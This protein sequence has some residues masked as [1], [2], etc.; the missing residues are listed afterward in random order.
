MQA[1]TS[2]ARREART[3]PRTP[4]PPQAPK[5]GARQSRGAVRSSRSLMRP[6]RRSSSHAPRHHTPPPLHARHPLRPQ[7]RPQPRANRRR[8]RAR[9]GPDLKLSHPCLRGT[10]RAR[11]SQPSPRCAQW[12]APAAASCTCALRR[13]N[14]S[15]SPRTSL[16]E[17]YFTCRTRP[18]PRP[19]R[20]RRTRHRR[21]G[22]SRYSTRW[23]RRCWSSRSA[24]RM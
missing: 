1:T 6:R 20:A 3:P 5:T 9:P 19:R 21:A 4:Q 7:P 24:W 2:R 13:R 10:T 16:R 12:A 15:R 18:R 11:R 8:H 14:S 23:R 22:D 17:G